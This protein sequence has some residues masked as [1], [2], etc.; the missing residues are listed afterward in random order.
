MGNDE[1]ECDNGVVATDEASVQKQLI[2]RSLSS[3]F[4]FFLVCSGM[5]FASHDLHVSGRS[6]E[7]ETTCFSRN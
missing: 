1:A 4:C 2:Q 3:L 5:E 7:L 6:V